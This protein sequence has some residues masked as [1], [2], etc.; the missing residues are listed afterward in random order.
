ML[1]AS[2]STI[3]IRRFALAAEPDDLFQRMRI[4]SKTPR[5]EI[6]LVSPFAV[7]CSVFRFIGSIVM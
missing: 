2:S 7:R 5:E 3:R 4:K 1:F 6:V